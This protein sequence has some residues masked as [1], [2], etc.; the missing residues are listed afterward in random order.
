MER[1]LLTRWFFLDQQLLPIERLTE[2]AFH[3][4]TLM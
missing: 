1:L 3:A 4:L 2:I